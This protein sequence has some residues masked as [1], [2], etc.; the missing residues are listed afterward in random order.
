[1]L[2]N[3]KA[4]LRSIE[5]NDFLD[6]EE[7]AAT[8]RVNPWDDFGWFTVSIGP[9]GDPGSNWFQVLV[10]TP[11]AVPRAKGNAKR[12]RGIIVESFEPTV[13][14]RSLQEYIA[15]LKGL[16]WQELVDQLRQ[17]MHWEYEGMGPA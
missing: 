1:L 3:V 7:F 6:W 10:S 9:E 14:A 15:S 17:T 4:E 11:S 5:S 13:I 16:T 12:F 2:G 8:E